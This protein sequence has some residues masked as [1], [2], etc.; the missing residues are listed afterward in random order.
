MPP[1]CSLQGA[2]A[3][4]D[5]YRLSARNY[6]GSI[7]NNINNILLFIVYIPSFECTISEKNTFPLGNKSYTV[8]G[9]DLID[10]GAHIIWNP[11]YKWTKYWHPFL[12]DEMFIAIKNCH[13]IFQTPFSIQLKTCPILSDTSFI[14]IYVLMSNLSGF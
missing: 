9:T 5:R 1:L 13:P 10:D 4:P 7:T 6:I 3:S 2:S 8:Q 12:S 14:L 11:C